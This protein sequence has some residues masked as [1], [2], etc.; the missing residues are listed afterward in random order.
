MM[1]E[2]VE[3]MK[4]VALV[5]I[6]GDRIHHTFLVGDFETPADAADWCERNQDVTMGLIATPQVMVAPEDWSERY[7]MHEAMLEFAREANGS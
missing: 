2:M 6:M 1:S 5:T 7:A 4:V 3:R